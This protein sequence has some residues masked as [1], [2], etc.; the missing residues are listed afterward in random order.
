MSL[1]IYVRQ[2]IVV[3]TD[4]LRRCYN[5]CNFSEEHVWSGWRFIMPSPNKESAESS[6]ATFQKINPSCE[7]K[8]KELV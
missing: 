3:N 8:I 1:E 7:Y 2:K 4:P 6:I 5:G